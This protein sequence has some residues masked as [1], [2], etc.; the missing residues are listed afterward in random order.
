MWTANSDNSD[1]V[2]EF[3]SEFVSFSDFVE[4]LSTDESVV[5]HVS[6]ADSGVHDLLIHLHSTDKN[7]SA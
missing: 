1:P 2:L 5:E 7:L 3:Q 6:T 4:V